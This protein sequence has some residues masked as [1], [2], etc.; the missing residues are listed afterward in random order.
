[1]RPARRAGVGTLQWLLSIVSTEIT[2]A[3]PQ[4]LN[5]TNF[6]FKETNHQAQIDYYTQF[7]TKVKVQ[8]CSLTAPK[9]RL[10]N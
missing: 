1:M 8:L 4:N 7:F 9:F 10:S 2:R 3:E 5:V 6:F